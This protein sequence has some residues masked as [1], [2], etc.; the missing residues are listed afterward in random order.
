MLQA[1]W[2][3]NAVPGPFVV[4]VFHFVRTLAGNLA[5]QGPRKAP[6][7][8]RGMLRADMRHR[9]AKRPIAQINRGEIAEPQSEVPCVQPSMFSRS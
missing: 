6:Q 2:T 7:P 5:G 9:I 3:Q 4:A 8:V 1:L